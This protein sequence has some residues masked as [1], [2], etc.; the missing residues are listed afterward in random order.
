[1]VNCESEEKDDGVSHFSLPYIFLYPQNKHGKN[2]MVA[3][4]KKS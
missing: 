3:A 4:C 2:N 1:M